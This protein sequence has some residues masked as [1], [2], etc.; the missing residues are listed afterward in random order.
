[1]TIEDPTITALVSYHLSSGEAL[2][3]LILLASTILLEMLN[4][5]IIPQDN[6]Y[7]SSKVTRTPERAFED[8]IESS[9]NL[10]YVYIEHK[11][12]RLRV[13]YVDQGD[14]NGKVEIV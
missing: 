8:V 5:I 9:G 7:I 3:G 10:N 2:M 14:H 1:M 6:S 4:S 12:Q 11:G 13:H